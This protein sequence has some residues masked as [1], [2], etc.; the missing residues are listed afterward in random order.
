[1]KNTLLL[2][3]F[4]LAVSVGA[5]SL[6]DSIKLDNVPLSNVVRLYFT[7]IN[8]DA[9]SLPDEL[10]KDERKIS[11]SI[12]GSSD[13]LRKN[14]IDILQ[15]YGYSITLERGL[16]SVQKVGGAV[17]APVD[18]DVFIYRPKARTSQY[19]SDVLRNV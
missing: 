13:Q 12:S 6:A 18:Q 10:I 15:G 7:E 4:L 16:Y 2:F 5:Q 3:V 14:L 19:L 17:V 9:F 11:L 8:K 1:M